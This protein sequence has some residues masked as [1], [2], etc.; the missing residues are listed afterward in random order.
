MRW[1]SPDINNGSVANLAIVKG[2]NLKIE[3]E[4]AVVTEEKLTC[5]KVKGVKRNNTQLSEKVPGFAH[6]TPLAK[7]NR[8]FK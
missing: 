7:L 3:E 6:K 8:A 2:V 1:S 4:K 5:Q